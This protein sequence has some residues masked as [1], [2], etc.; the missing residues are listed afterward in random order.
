MAS[1]ASEDGEVGFQIAPMVDVV[2][3][4]MLFFM[5]SAGAQI[6][7]KE[8]SIR[9]PGQVQP[10]SAILPPINIEI[11]ADG[12]ITMNGTEYAAPSDLS[13]DRLEAKL[14]QLAAA[15]DPAHPDSVVI[16]PDPDATQER[17]IA[18]LNATAA[19]GVKNLSFR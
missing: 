11:A 10:G 14:V 15:G 9:L 16:A 7:E 1:I 8:L 13:L 17:V 18:V 19:A 2:F 6:L 3:V 4:L 12:V 5:A